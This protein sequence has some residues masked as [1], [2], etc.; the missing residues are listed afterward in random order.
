[1][2][3]TPDQKPGRNVCLSG[4]SRAPEK[5]VDVLFVAVA[6]RQTES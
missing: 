2:S 6:L 4:R 1:M 5:P 3:R